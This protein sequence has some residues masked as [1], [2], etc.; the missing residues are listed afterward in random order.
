MMGLENPHTLLHTTDCLDSRITMKS[1]T[2]ERKQQKKLLRKLG[3]DLEKIRSFG[4]STTFPKKK[5]FMQ[6]RKARFSLLS[7]PG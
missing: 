5:K 4:V 3:A 7:V 2:G 6:V 1:N